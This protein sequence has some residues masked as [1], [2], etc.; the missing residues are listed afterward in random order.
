M[1]RQADALELL[2]VTRQRLVDEL[3]VDPG[4]GLRAVETAILQQDPTVMGSPAPASATPEPSPVPAPRMP[5]VDDLAGPV[6]L[7][8]L[9]GRDKQLAALEAELAAAESGQPRFAALVGEPGIGKSRLTEELAAVAAARGS[10]PSTDA[11]RRT[12]ARPRC[13]RG[14]R[15]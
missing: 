1:G 6:P 4:P 3:G 8:P 12:T 15:S 13:S 11:A 2:R 7:W 9:V 5:A 10:P 14:A